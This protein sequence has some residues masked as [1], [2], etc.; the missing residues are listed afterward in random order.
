[1]LEAETVGGV[2]LHFN[3]QDSLTLD[4]RRRGED[5]RALRWNV[6]DEMCAKRVKANFISFKNTST[7]VSMN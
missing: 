6:M 4:R 5:C 7:L 1:M 3:N 2:T